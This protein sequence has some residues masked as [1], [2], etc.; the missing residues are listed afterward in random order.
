MHLKGPAV[1]Q[2]IEEQNNGNIYSVPDFLD[3]RI[4]MVSIK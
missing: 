2:T 1:K 3:I 4:L